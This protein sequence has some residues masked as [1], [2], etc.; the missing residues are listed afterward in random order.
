MRQAASAAISA[1][2]TDFMLSRVP[3]NID[4]PLVDEDQRRAVALLAGDADVRAA[5]AGGDLPVDGA[6][7]VARQ[8]GAQL[9]ELEPAAADPG[10]AAAGEDAAD[11]LARQEVEAARPRFEAREVGQVD[12]DARVG[13]G[14]RGLRRRRRA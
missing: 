9:L 3:K 5:G 11:R 6:D 7:V 4:M 14:H 8:V 1:A 12:M 10:G 13:G 2:V